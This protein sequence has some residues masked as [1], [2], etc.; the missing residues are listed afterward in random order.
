MTI[1]AFAFD[2][3]ADSAADLICNVIDLLK[4]ALVS[5]R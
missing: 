3:A 4:Q 2:L 5:A 1:A